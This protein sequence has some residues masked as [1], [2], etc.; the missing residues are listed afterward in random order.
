K[1]LPSIQRKQGPELQAGM[2]VTDTGSGAILALVGSRKADETGGF[3]RAL[4]AQR[5]VGSL[6]KPFVYL[7]ALA[8]P[9]RFSLATWVDDSPV[10]VTQPNGKTWRPKNSDGKS[11]GTVTLTSALAR[12]Y[13][14]ATVRVG[15]EVGPDRLSELLKV[16][17]GLKAT[18]NPSLILGAV[19]LNVMSM[20][21]M[22]QFLASG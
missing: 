3:N 13:N 4:K 11:H 1:V 22:Y 19:D 21:Q 9:D 14:Q 18:P 6:L 8:Q 20:T 10:E 12:S 5:P 7:L 15:M 17:A 2:V 16:L